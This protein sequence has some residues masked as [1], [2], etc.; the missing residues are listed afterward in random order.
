MNGPG[1]KDFER[2]FFLDSPELTGARWWQQSV[3]ETRAASQDWESA[4]GPYDR[5][6]QTVSTRRGA[7]SAI[8]SLG[9]GLLVIG[10]C[11]ASIV[12]DFSSGS[13]DPLDD[14]HEDALALQQAQGW[15]IGAT[16]QALSFPDG[17]SQDAS[18]Q[19]QWRNAISTL[20]IELSP[21]TEAYRPW[22][23]PTLLRA[24]GQTLNA[25]LAQALQPI[26]SNAMDLAYSKGLA[27]AELFDA[28]PTSAQDTLLVIDLPGPEAVALAAALAWRFEPV[29][30]LDNC[31]HPRGVVPA[32]LTLAAI[33]FELPLFRD[34][35]SARQTPAPMMLVLD[36]NRLTPY[37]DSGNIFD[38][39]WLAKI[40]SASE[41]QRLGVKQ[42][43]YVAP[44]G[45][46]HE[47]DDL[48]DDFVA[49]A[50]ASVDLRL[51]PISDLREENPADLANAPTDTV[52]GELYQPVDN[53]AQ[54]AN[55]T[56]RGHQVQRYYWGGSRA[57]HVHF[58]QAY[59]PYLGIR[60]HFSPFRGSGVS[61]GW[62]PSMRSTMFS[63]RGFGGGGFGGGGGWRSRSSSGFGRV[64]HS[65]WGSSSSGRSGSLGRSSFFGGG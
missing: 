29:F 49:L 44:S 7:L 50:N 54:Y 28:M 3:V 53:Q 58:W 52:P 16:N 17:V 61:I 25:S 56:W 22:Y 10:K 47:L 24:P 33:L 42:L 38:N 21:A 36:A 14:A 65:H 39:R 32:H 40:P 27:L 30:G 2:L 31:P 13:S 48:N 34:A 57:M 26:H 4:P 62:H 45:A 55:S 8:F 46:E 18:N 19:S 9:I 51:L 1:N 20:D 11:T 60:M 37:T 41:L 15:D 12:Q 35:A 64:S 43:I 63:G 6:V 59:R 5:P 23:V